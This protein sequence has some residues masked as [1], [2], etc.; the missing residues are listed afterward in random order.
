VPA[1]YAFT[2]RLPEPVYKAARR[3]AKRER[4]SLNR[5]VQK[6]IAE[7]ARNATTARLSAAYE[8]LASD[9]AE[10]DVSSLLAV[11]AEAVLND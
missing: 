11:Q 2:V 9:R 4:I 3:M 10:A 1:L 5:L 8:A 6:A 7:Q